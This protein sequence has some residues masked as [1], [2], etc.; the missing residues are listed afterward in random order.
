VF[1]VFLAQKLAGQPMTVIG[2]GTQTRDFTFVTDVVDAF[3][4]AAASEA[5]GEVFNVGSGNT[6]AVNRLVELLGGPTT[7]IPKRPGEPDCTFADIGK[8]QAQLGWRPR[9]SFEEGVRVMVDRI[10]D[11]RQA[12]VWTPEAIAD[13][14]RDWF[15]HLGAGAPTTA[16]V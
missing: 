5:V 8:I 3:V 6:Y 7:H 2:D 9:V 13:A 4:E 11:W 10:E 1:G 14:T 16:A 12:P 15:R